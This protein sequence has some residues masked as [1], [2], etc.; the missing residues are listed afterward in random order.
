[1]DCSK[2]VVDPIK[3]LRAFNFGGVG[4]LPNGTVLLLI[5]YYYLENHNDLLLQVPLLVD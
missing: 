2:I 1:M 4:T 3:Y 5:G